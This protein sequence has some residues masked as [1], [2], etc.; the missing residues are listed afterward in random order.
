MIFLIGAIA[1]IL[2]AVIYFVIGSGETQSWNERRLN[3]QQSQRSVATVKII[4]ID[5]VDEKE[6]STKF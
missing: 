5:I 6:L 2:P 3:G 1:Y 4:D